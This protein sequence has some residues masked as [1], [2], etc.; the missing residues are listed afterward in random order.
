MPVIARDRQLLGHLAR[1]NRN[2]G[3]A[4]VE[5]CDRQD[6]GELPVDG[7]LAL[8]ERLDTAA[9]ACRD[10]AAELTTHQTA[11]DAAPPTHSEPAE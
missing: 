8:A 2:L 9:T 4:I 7:L 6:G 10:R 1:I 5:L 11:V 3:L